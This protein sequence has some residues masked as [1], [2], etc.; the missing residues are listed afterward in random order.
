MKF[1]EVYSILNET[2]PKGSCMYWAEVY[3]KQLIKDK[4]KNALIHE[5]YVTFSMMEDKTK[6]KS[7]RFQHTWVTVNKKIIDGTLDQF[8]GWDL[9]TVKYIE[10][11]KYTPE[12]YSELCKKYPVDP[13][14]F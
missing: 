7:P 13:V 2:S 1:N 12:E 3:T 14:K 6:M 4:T 11:K 9:S 5:G 8:N 10:R